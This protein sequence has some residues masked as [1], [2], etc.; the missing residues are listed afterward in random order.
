MRD[1]REVNLTAPRRVVLDV[2][3]DPRVEPRPRIRTL[4]PAADR[5]RKILGEAKEAVATEDDGTSSE[6]KI[7][8][9]TWRIFRQGLVKE[10]SSQAYPDDDAAEAWKTLVRR[11][12]IAKREPIFE[13]PVHF[14]LALFL[15]RPASSIRK[16]MPNPR[17]WDERKVHPGGDWDNFAKSTSDALTG[18]A[19]N[20]DSSITIGVVYKIR[21]DGIEKPGA[22]VIIREAG[23]VEE[24]SARLR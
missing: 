10:T 23:D 24:I 7:E 20:D 11:A 8:A 9:E 17:N 12:W 1:C 4:L 3:G 21:C 6:K 16:T 5:L 18:L 2:A 13:G 22:R 19:Y 15:Y 14:V